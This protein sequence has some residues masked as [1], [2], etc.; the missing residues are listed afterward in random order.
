MGLL[1]KAGPWLAGMMQK[2]A[3]P[4]GTITYVRGPERIALTGKAWVGR[5]VFS[6]TTKDGGAAVVFGDRDY[7]CPVPDLAQGGVPF[8][9]EK[10]HQ[11]EE[12]I[13]GRTVVFEVLSQPNEPGA[14][15]SD[16]ARTVWRIHTKERGSE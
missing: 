7:L 9:P 10:G 1:N 14:R 8:E 11:V 16:P 2:A 15:Y 3:A 5:T 6:R 12:V 13:G 4:E